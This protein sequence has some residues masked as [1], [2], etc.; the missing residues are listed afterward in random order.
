MTAEPNYLYGVVPS[1]GERSY[2]PIGLGGGEVRTV[3]EGGIGIVAS[4]GERIPLATVS[5]EKALQC[6]AQHQRVLEQVM[7]DAPVLPLKFGTYAEDDRQILAILR[8]GSPAFAGALEKYAGKVEVDL[9][10]FWT[11]L[12]AVLAETAGH[13]A[14]VSM[15]ARL[16]S[17]GPPTTE[18][19]IELGQMVKMLL[20]HRREQVAGEL[21]A[22]LREKWPQAIVHAAPDDTMVFS[23]ALLIGRDE[24][25]RFD[26]AVEDLNRRHEGWLRFRRVGP[27]PPYSFATVE[28]RTI[29]TAELDAARQALELGES[30][31]LAEIKA[32]HR[33][34]LQHVHPDRNA[35]VWAAQRTQEITA[36]FDLLEEYAVN[37]KHN[38]L[39]A[40]DGPVI[41]KVK[42]L[43]DLRGGAKSPARQE[44]GS[45]S[46][47]VRVE[48]A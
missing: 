24:Q 5:P 37:F 6:L 31:S 46:V 1:E 19:R 3:S 48:A 20:D 29:E 42:S 40:Q 47:R 32:A 38:F 25:A 33:R 30:A 22:A 2:G 21:A 36:A 14:I 26:G 4:Q 9:G 34:R 41:V 13:E 28:V 7:L 12:Q 45:R 43:A 18:Q 27:L 17:Q 39:T 16:A 10:V 35:E 23:A 15:K 44:P 8:S 11:D